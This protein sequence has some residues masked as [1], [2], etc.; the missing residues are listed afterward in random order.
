MLH[1]LFFAFLAQ[2]FLVKPPVRVDIGNTTEVENV[3]A[4]SEDRFG[5][6]VWID[7]SL[8]SEHVWCATS[9]DHGRTFSTPVQVDTDT[10]GSDKSLLARSVRVRNQEIYV[11]WL[12]DR[13]GRADAYFRASR[14]GGQSWEPEIRLDD[15]YTPG[16][17]RVEYL[18]MMLDPGVGL[19][20]ALQSDWTPNGDEV[21]VVGSANFGQSFQ[22][23]S[24]IHAGG[25][26]SRIDVDVERPAIHVIWQDDVNLPGVPEPYY[27]RS[28]DGGQTWLSNSIPL[29]P[30]MWTDPSDLRI[31]AEG[32]RVAIVFQEVSALC[33]IAINVSNDGGDSWLP[34]P[35]RVAGALSPTCVP[36]NPRLLF[37]P[38]HLVVAW[39]DDRAVAGFRTP[40]LAWTQDD[41]QSWEERQLLP[42]FGFDLRIQGDS[43]NGTFAVMWNG[44]AQ[45][46]AVVSQSATP[47]PG[48]VF[49]V[50]GANSSS[51][52]GVTLRR[53]SAY[54][55]MLA[56]WMERDRNGPLQVWAAGFRGPTILPRGSFQAGGS[57]HFEIMQFPHNETGWEYQALVSNYFGNAALPFGDG[58]SVGLRQHPWLVISA[59]NPNLRGTIQADGTGTTPASI[60]PPG[61]PPF[62]PLY[63]AAVAIGPGLTFGSITDVR[64]V[65]T[66]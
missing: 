56:V 4:A 16:N 9:E 60:F 12:D 20:I 43:S 45:I 57:V 61:I 30:G 52:E 28:S 13:N 24:L 58:R 44:A 15:G 49:V 34:N 48:T 18:K 5:A 36:R 3:A 27:Q 47:N 41:G 40:Y 55:D 2:D 38:T 6:V 39:S 29:A 1:A 42:T 50:D 21:R 35:R 14:D 31:E 25:N 62:T 53:D 19:L 32:S 64:K 51:M 22:P 7:T 17:A 10:S 26:I 23:S 54:E 46:Y 59:T 37:T 33:S 8:G 65:F 66:L 63:M 11:S